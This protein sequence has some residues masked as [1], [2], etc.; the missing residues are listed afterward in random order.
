MPSSRER[1]LDEDELVEHCRFAIYDMLTGQVIEAGL[2]LENI[3]NESAPY[4]FR[5]LTAK[6]VM[7]ASFNAYLTQLD[8][9]YLLLDGVYWEEH[10]EELEQLPRIP[11]IPIDR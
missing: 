5:V 1:Y 3:S 9:R 4:V 2:I 7:E 8:E 10:L 11:H 6:G